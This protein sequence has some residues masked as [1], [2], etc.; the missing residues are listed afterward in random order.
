[1]KDFKNLVVFIYT[2]SGEQIFCIIVDEDTNNIYYE[3]DY[4]KG[5]VP[6][7]EIRRIHIVGKVVK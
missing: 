6:K 5:Y 3:N 1:M 7:D 2:K 4:T